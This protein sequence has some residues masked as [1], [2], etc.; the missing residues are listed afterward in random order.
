MSIKVI[1]WVMEDAPV[2]SPSEMV[3]LYALADRAHEDGTC[4]WPSHQWIAD[5]AVCSRRT[6]IRHLKA[7]EKRG[8]IRRGDQQFVR[9]IPADR[10]PVVWDLNLSM[11]RQNVTPQ[12]D[13]KDLETGCQNVTPQDDGVTNGATTGCHTVHDDVTNGARRGDT[14]V[15]Q[16]V[17]KPS[18]NRPKNHPPIVP[19]GGR[20]TY[21]ASFEEF[22]KTYP[23]RVGKRTAFKA[24]ERAIKRAG[25]EEILFGAQALAR[26]PN[27]PQEQFIPHPTTWLNRDGWEDAQMPSAEPDSM[28]AADYMAVWGIG[29]DQG[30]VIEG[31]VVDVD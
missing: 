6:V 10:R 13:G 14:G 17:L 7:L 12:D 18:L 26:D 16:T 23:R 2:Q 4:A 8:L 5:R 29:S 28:S 11:T 19:H 27:L 15:T 9:H 1:S 3:I 22:W 31:E 30:D 24:W 21:P 20:T 25:E